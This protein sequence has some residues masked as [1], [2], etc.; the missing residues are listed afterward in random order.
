MEGSGSVSLTNGSGCGSGRP[1]NIWILW[2]RICKTGWFWLE[3][4]D[5]E[6]NQPA[7]HCAGG[8]LP[9]SCSS[10]LIRFSAMLHNLTSLKQQNFI[11]NSVA[12]PDPGSEIKCLFDPCIRDPRWGKNQH[13]DPDPGL[14]SWI[15][16]TSVSLK[17]ILVKVPYLNSLMWIR[18]LKI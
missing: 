1:K 14:T 10:L 12:D 6:K 8:S 13:H 3:N 11:N 9:R 16:G 2:I 7:E 18:D 4:T 17:T 5:G 15:I